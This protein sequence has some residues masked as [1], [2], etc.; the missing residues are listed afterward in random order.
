VAKGEVIWVASSRPGAGKTRVAVALIEALR[1]AGRQPVGVKPI[2]LAAGYGEDHD[3]TSAD[4]EA[5]GVAA[6]VAVPPLVRAPYRFA[7]FTAPTAATER[8]GIELGLEDLIA[9]IVA[10]AE[11]GAPVIVDSPSDAHA[12]LYPGGSG[13]DVARH[14]GAHVV[15]V[16]PDEATIAATRSRGLSFTIAVDPESTAEWDRIAREVL[17]ALAG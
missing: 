6:G 5:L 7:A 16:A 8:L 4:A 1:R 2:E 3:L 9:T 13:L 14:L 11:Y 10:A 15:I 17:D 12:P